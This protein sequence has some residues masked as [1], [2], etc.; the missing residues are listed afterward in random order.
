VDTAGQDEYSIMPP[1]YSVDIHGYILVYSIDSRK[2]FDVCSTLHEK[3]VDL[4]GS[5]TF[6]AL[7]FMFPAGISGTLLFSINFRVPIVLVGN[8]SDLRMDREVSRE[9]GQRLAA[10]MKA[11]FLETSARNNQVL[12]NLERRSFIE[13]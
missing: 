1:N 5:N 2:S 11:A 7:L 8:K 12:Y 6:V 4:I 9:D 3:L 10:T 13:S